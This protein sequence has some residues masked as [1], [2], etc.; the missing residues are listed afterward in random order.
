MEDRHCR[1]YFLAPQQTTH[2]RYEALRA[3]FVA[4][5]PLAVVAQR[6]GYKVSALKSM[7]CRFRAECRRG[8]TPPFSYPTAAGGIPGR[9]MA[10]TDTGRNCPRSPTAES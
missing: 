9:V 3:V 6:F 10:A 7:A 8:S 4:G 2:R 1:Q 5:E